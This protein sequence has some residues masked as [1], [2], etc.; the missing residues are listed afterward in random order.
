M[1]KSLKLTISGV[2]SI[3]YLF[4]ISTFEFEYLCIFSSTL[5]NFKVSYIF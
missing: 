4:N 1:L 3:F 2:L 5:D